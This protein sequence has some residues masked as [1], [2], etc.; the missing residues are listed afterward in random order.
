M[1]PIV[2]LPDNRRSLFSTHSMRHY[3]DTEAKDRQHNKQ[4][5]TNQY[6]S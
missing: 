1:K 2:I 5:T 6:F 4:E 3:P